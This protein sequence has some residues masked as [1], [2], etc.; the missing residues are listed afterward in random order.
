MVF[1][2]TSFRYGN[3]SGIRN[4]RFFQNMTKE[5][6]NRLLNEMPNYEIISSKITSDVR[7]GREEEKWLN[8]FLKRK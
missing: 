5:E 6:Y 1:F 4:G 8:I 7:P 2:Y 3:F